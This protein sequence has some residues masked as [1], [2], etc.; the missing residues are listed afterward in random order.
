MSPISLLKQD[1]DTDQKLSDDESED[2]GESTL[3]SNIEE[4]DFDHQEEV[5]LLG[6]ARWDKLLWTTWVPLPKQR[7]RADTVIACPPLPNSWNT[8]GAMAPALLKR[9]KSILLNKLS[10]SDHAPSTQA[11]PL[12]M[13]SGDQNVPQPKASADQN[14]PQNQK[15]NFEVAKRFMEAIV[16]KRTPRPISSDDQY[17][18]VAEAWKLALEAQDRQRAL[19]GAPVGPPSLCQLPGSPSL[20][21]DP[22]TPEAVSL[23]FC[24]MLL[25]QISDIDYAPKYT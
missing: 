18:M 19:A 25:Y 16:F 13:F 12:R 5:V 7:I 6:Q 10:K 9:K 24:L 23:G 4:D 11:L 3:S 1:D 8:A 15:P 17:S 22:Q 20:K 14:V 2:P 21:I